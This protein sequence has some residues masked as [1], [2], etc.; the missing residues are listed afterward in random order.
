MNTQ[1]TVRRKLVASNDGRRRW[2]DAYQFLLRWT[3]EREAEVD[4]APLLY[5]E[6]QHGSRSV[7]SRIDQPSTA[8]SDD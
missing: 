1:W 6:D 4:S 2:D 7:C 3:M 5:Q 8:S